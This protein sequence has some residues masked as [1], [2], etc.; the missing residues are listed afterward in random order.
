MPTIYRF[1]TLYRLA[2]RVGYGTDYGPRHAL[3]APAGAAST[4][5]PS[6]CARGARCPW[7]ARSCCRQAYISSTTSP[8]PCFH[9][10]GRPLGASS[11][12]PSP[13]ATCRGRGSARPAG[14]RDLDRRCGIPV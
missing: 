8:T 14:S 5:A 3:V 11:S 6:M 2:M 10:C 1:P 7:P 12:S 4:C 9:A 13:C